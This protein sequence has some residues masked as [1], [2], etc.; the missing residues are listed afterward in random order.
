V[1]RVGDYVIVRI[2]SDL[3][4]HENIAMYLNDL[5][6]RVLPL[7]RAADGLQSVSVLQ[8][9]LVAYGEVATLSAW[10]S[11]EAMLQFFRMPLPV[12]LGIVIQRDPLIFQVVLS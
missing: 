2:C 1:I 3:V 5:S 10:D 11:E 8:R 4:V 9:E 12:P 6:K 7:Y